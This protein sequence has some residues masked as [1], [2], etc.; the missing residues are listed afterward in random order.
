MT[1]LLL[2]TFDANGG[3][4]IATHRIHHALL[5]LGLNSRMLVQRKFTDDP[6]VIQ[7]APFL[8]RASILIRPH[9]DNLPLQLKGVVPKRLFSGSV[10]PESLSTQI[11]EINP[12]II[13]LFWVQAG[14]VRIETLANLKKPIVWTLHDMWPFT[15][16]C[17]YDDECGRYRESC[18][19]CP[20]L[21]SSKSQD[22]SFRVWARK[23][24]SWSRIPI[25]IVATSQWL[26]D[27]AR[28][29]SLFRHQRIE[30]IPNC[31]DS[32]RY[33][34]LA[35]SVAR[36]V[37]GLPK[38]KRLVL[39]SA[40]NVA[41]DPRKGFHLLIPA[42][43][44]IAED[45]SNSNIE[46]VVLGASKPASPLDIGLKVHYMGKMQDDISQVVLYSAIDVLVAPSMQENLSNTV[47]ETL[48]C[49]RPV[50]AFD[51]GG[52]PD[53]ISHMKNGY[54]AKPL[55]SDALAA[56]ILWVLEN[57]IRWQ[58][59]SSHA[60]ETATGRYSKSIIAE[61]YANLYQDMTK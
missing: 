51:I 61:Q 39:I 15:G 27:C 56:G 60:R 34:P 57:N 55:E 4:A 29:S 44:R 19:H 14:F 53:M 35:Q 49:G 22:Y 2:N 6:T 25:T 11:S 36:D 30:V 54:L 32:G 26:A 21:G 47:L 10:L 24:Q 59:L 52:M 28:E 16:G 5:D 38:D 3:A 42:L 48:F 12:D 50:V 45:N 20:V 31:V 1:P 17:H 40:M 58:M 8:H 9:L 43:K 7:A 23:Q 37:L 41:D 18:G 33:K 46:L 13:H